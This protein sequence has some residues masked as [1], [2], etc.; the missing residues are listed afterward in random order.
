MRQL[1]PRSYARAGILALTLVS[2]A[3]SSSLFAQDNKRTAASPSGPTVELSLIVTN[4]AKKSLD[5][6]NKEDVHVFEDKDEQTVLSVE[7]DERPIDC[8]VA[9]DSSGSFRSLFVTALEAAKLVVMNRRSEDEIMIERFISSDKIQSVI[10]FT[11][12]EKA[13]VAALDMLYVERGQSAVIDAVYVAAKTFADLNKTGKDRRRVIVIITD[14]EDRNSY[15]KQD[16]LVKVLR[17]SDV[18]IFALG[19]VTELDRD[20][21]FARP[22]ARSRAEKLLQT[23]TAETGGRVFFP[24]DKTELLD[25]MQ[26]IITDLRGQFRLT[27]QSSNGEKKGFRKVEVKLVSPAGEKWNAI[28]PRGYESR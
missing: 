13:L 4:S 24:R 21:R 28:V 19:F 14:G 18:Q 3:L 25:S 7:R 9:I 8:L 26:Q 27:Y 6:I 22:D 10:K 17:Q 23:I 20:P 5:K 1:S 2:L 15:Y 12:D 16:A 11:R